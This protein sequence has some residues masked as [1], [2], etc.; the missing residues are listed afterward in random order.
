MPSSPRH[1]PRVL[2]DDVI[3]IGV[4]TAKWSLDLKDV[5]CDLEPVLVAN[6]VW[7]YAVA[8]TLIEGVQQVDASGTKL[9]GNPIFWSVIQQA[10]PKNDKFYEDISKKWPISFLR[11]ALSGTSL[12][13]DFRRRGQRRRR[14][15]GLATTGSFRLGTLISHD[16]DGDEVAAA[17]GASG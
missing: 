8:L 1:P 14:A 15:S 5:R 17:T 9:Q 4:L 3:V 13:L 2:P 12:Y 10:E 11:R 7:H 16:K 6:Y